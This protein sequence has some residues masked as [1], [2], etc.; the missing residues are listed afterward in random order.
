MLIAF[1]Q[2][3]YPQSL[4]L[5]QN[6]LVTNTFKKLAVGD[7]MPDITLTNLLNYSGG[8]AKLSD[9]KG[10]L[11]I[12][13]FW[14][15]GCK[16]CIGA[17]PKMEK[18]QNEFKDKIQVLA[19]TKE[20]RGSIQWLFERSD[21]VKN[22]TLTL[23][24]GDKELNQLFPHKAEPF[25]VWI[26]KDRIIRAMTT[27]RNATS[28]NIRDFLDGKNVKMATPNFPD[29]NYDKSILLEGGGRQIENLEYYS[30]ITKIGTNSG[31][32]S[33]LTDSAT[34]KFIGFQIFNSTA[35]DLFRAAFDMP[36]R[37]NRVIYE[38]ANTEKI[39]IS[40]NKIDE[41]KNYY[42]YEI[43]APQNKWN[44]IMQKDFQIYFN[45]DASLEKRNMRCYVIKRS[46]DKVTE[47]HIKLLSDSN[48]SRPYYELYEKRFKI[49]N[50]SF[51]TFVSEFIKRNLDYYKSKALPV[52]DE[53]G[54]GNRKVNMDIHSIFTDIPS[55]NKEINKYGLEIIEEERTLDIL[56]LKESKEEVK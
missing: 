11:I 50:S 55:L 47:N 43:K 39:F 15:S 27:G 8:K 6:Q 35:L 9:F 30:L 49:T 17:F 13:D 37:D 16:V 51:Q 56:L 21:I 14:S 36:Y 24:L 29:Y 20:S 33:L 46:E 19:V 38:S 52:I 54:Y 40:D 7:L 2:I 25:H 32:K 12:L 41:W 28:E 34:G 10:K 44:K 22:T 53:T 3:G 4:T 31:I 48:T 42:S 18:L 1:S 23:A 26:D 45:V 5:S